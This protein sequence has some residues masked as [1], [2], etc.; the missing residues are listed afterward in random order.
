[1]HW[2][3]GP[4][5]PQSQDAPG[6]KPA[7]GRPGF[8]VLLLGPRAPA[9]ANGS[10]TQ[11]KLSAAPRLGAPCRRHHDPH[12]GNSGPGPGL[13]TTADAPAARLRFSFSPNQR[14][15]NLPSTGLRS[16]PFFWFEVL[17]TTKAPTLSARV[18]SL[19]WILTRRR[20][21][22]SR[23][24]PADPTPAWCTSAALSRKQRRSS[25]TQAARCHGGG[26]RSARHA[27]SRSRGRCKR[28]TRRRGGCGCA[29][30]QRRATSGFSRRILWLT[31][32]VARNSSSNGQL[33]TVCYSGSYRM[34]T[35]HLTWSLALWHFKLVL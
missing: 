2:R 26:T 35:P 21:G 20:L 33:E 19:A 11:E 6:I 25:R 34:G 1:L 5:Q 12:R 14:C 15:S 13:Q 3:P 7:P 16:H 27:G 24:A 30:R 4:D 28:G 31:V 8:G 18:Q 10:P 9:G 32:A 23:V 29:M 22:S 17:L